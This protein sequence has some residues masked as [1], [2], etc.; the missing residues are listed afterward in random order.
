M[1]HKKTPT[2]TWRSEVGEAVDYYFVYGETPARIMANYR[3]VSGHVPLLPKYAWGY[4]Q[5][6]ERYRSSQ[7]LI[8]AVDRFRMRNIPVDIIV[9]DWQWWGTD[10]NIWNSL[11]WDNRFYPDVP[12][13]VKTLHEK[14]THFIVSVWP[15]FGPQTEVRK[16]LTD[17]GCMVG[18][19]QCMDPTNSKAR[20]IYWKHIKNTI[21][22]Q[23]V[24]GYWQDATEPECNDSS[25]NC[26]HDG[27]IYLGSGARYLNSYPLFATQALYDGNRAAT[28]GTKRLCDLTRSG[29]AGIQRYGVISWSG[30]IAGSWECFQRQ[31][32]AGLGYASAGLPYWT[33]D[34]GGF[35]RPGSHLGLAG[36][37]F[38]TPDHLERLCRWMQCETFFPV[39][40]M[41]GLDTQTEPWRFGPAEPVLTQYIKFRY[42]F[43][44]YIYSCSWQ[45]HQGGTLMKP[46]TMDFPQEMDLRNITNQFMFGDSLLVAPIVEPSSSTEAKNMATTT[47]AI[48]LSAKAFTSNP[49]PT[50]A[51]PA[52][53]SVVLPAAAKWYDFWSG[54][55]VGNGTITVAAPI[56]TI[57]LFV[58]AG[59]ILP[60]GPEL[61]HTGEKSV[62]PTELRVYP[63][64]DSAFTLYDDAGE[65]Y[66]YED[67]EYAKWS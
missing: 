12:L 16:E 33:T 57:P 8:E 13:L 26:W 20:E 27:Q 30:D 19:S 25:D 22:D 61:Q 49:T 38:T 2:T 53:R 3:A 28:N 59:S 44:P 11:I 39:Q 40:R 32:P 10:R 9:Q 50:F 51:G 56:D 34:I 17:A 29:Y 63:G 1:I 15:N 54:K 14:N 48:T 64:T 6:R 37:Q 55:P 60:F 45:V 66:N 47:P 36:D 62:K 18:N 58:K 5:C 43:L 31:I 21:A 23:G 41:H 35:F 7:E 67:G 46:M 65:G 52:I 24:D 4:W 42:R